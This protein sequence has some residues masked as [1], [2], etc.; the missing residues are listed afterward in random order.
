[1]E[2]ILLGFCI[3]IFPPPHPSPIEQNAQIIGFISIR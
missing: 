2:K 1:L 3:L